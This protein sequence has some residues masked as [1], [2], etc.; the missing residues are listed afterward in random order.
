MKESSDGDTL[1]AAGILYVYSSKTETQATQQY[2]IQEIRK[3]TERKLDKCN[4]QEVPKAL[5]NFINR[6]MP[7]G[8][9][10]CNIK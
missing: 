5:N 7:L 10:K 2:N 3:K 4:V 1:M 6:P 9:I 8:L